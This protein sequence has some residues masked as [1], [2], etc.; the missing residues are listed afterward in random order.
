MLCLK[1]NKKKKKLGFLDK[2]TSESMGLELVYVKYPMY[3]GE[4]NQLMH[5]H[6]TPST[7]TICVH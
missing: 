3:V 5:Y 4:T 1:T 2:A 7:Q 6:D